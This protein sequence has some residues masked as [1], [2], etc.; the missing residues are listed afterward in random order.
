MIQSILSKV[1]GS[2]SRTSVILVLVAGFIA[3][4]GTSAVAQESAKSKANPYALQASK[5]GLTVYQL[6]TANQNQIEAGKS[7]LTSNTETM[8]GTLNEASAALLK[9]R[10]M[11]QSSVLADVTLDVAPEISLIERLASANAFVNNAL[12]QSQLLTEYN[13]AK[14]Y[15]NLN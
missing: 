13:T 8:R 10:Y 14:A 5:L 15:F 1:K 7:T 3:F 12:T 2:A 9:F 11:Y 6:G 4:G